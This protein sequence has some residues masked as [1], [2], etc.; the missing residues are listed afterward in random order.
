MM[1]KKIEELYSQTFLLFDDD[2]KAQLHKGGWVAGLGLILIGL[3]LG[4]IYPWATFLSGFGVG[5]ILF[6]RIMF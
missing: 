5:L 3:G 6:T 2:V 4:S 1:R